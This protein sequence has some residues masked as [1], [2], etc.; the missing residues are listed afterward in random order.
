MLERK[1]GLI[2]F[3]IFIV[4]GLML[5]AAYF[6]AFFLYWLV[7]GRAS[8]NGATALIV[9]FLALLIVEIF[10]TSNAK[11]LRRKTLDEFISCFRN[12]VFFSL[13]LSFLIFVIHAVDDVSRMVTLFTVILYFILDFLARILLKK[14]LLQ[15][16]GHQSDRI[17]LCTDRQHAGDFIQS[18]NNTPGSYRRVTAV[19]LTETPVPGEKIQDVPVV[20]ALP[21]MF[22]Y[23]RE[24]IVDEA[25]LFLPDTDDREIRRY[26]DEFES[27]GI[28][29]SMILKDFE[30]TGNY[31]ANASVIGGYPAMT[32][33]RAVRNPQQMMLKRIADIF[34]GFVGSLIAGIL[35]LILGPI[36]KLDSKGPVL[37]RQ[38]RVGRNGRFFMM[39]KFRSM[40]PDAEEQKKELLKKNEVQGQM[41]KLTDDPRITRVGRFLRRSSLDEFPQFFNILKGDMS[42][43][44]TRPPTVDEFMKYEDHHKRRL[45]MK[46]GLT[47]LWQVSG[48][49]EI[50]DFEE[51][52]RL[53][54]QYIDNWSLMLDLKI[55][56]RTIAVVFRRKGSK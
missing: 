54:C 40:V 39:Y 17:L 53:D 42:L 33:S 27:M 16:A 41:F 24:Q 51:V 52:V 19:A 46:P 6:A 8:E 11:F 20:S 30:G 21:D 14:L 37:F 29:A 36:I 49:S 35:F 34:S 22:S 2:N 32:F 28:V 1:G 3:Y 18:F 9:H 38:K 10:L 13:I 4:D 50:T 47:G 48:R 44:G 55:F 12:V 7:R 5:T 56:L 23:A 26:I 45:S 31:V 25:V 15:R 43:I